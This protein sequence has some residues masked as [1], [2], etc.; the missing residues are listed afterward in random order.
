VIR[1]GKQTDWFQ[2]MRRILAGHPD[3]E[4]ELVHRYQGGINIIIGRVVRNDAVIE[5]LSQE[6]F[7]IVLEKIRAG[8][9]REPERLSG[10]ICGVAQNLA[11]DYVRRIR[12]TVQQEERGVPEQICDSQ[13]D[14]FEQLWRKE[15]AQ[16]VR[17]VI[18]E[19]KVQRDREVLF[20]YYIAE[21]DKEQVCA[22]LGLNSQQFN[23]IIFRALKRYRELYLK[24]V[25]QP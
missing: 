24:H 8:E 11:I 17:Q 14:P 16:I 13:P 4:A 18:G 5:D 3:A 2:W 25:G 12:R 22:D 10:F 21:E 7:R 15:R 23:T 9:V 20:R 6:T 1:V 19:L